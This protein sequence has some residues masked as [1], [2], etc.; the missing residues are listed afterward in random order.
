MRVLVTGAGGFVGLHLLRELSRAGSREL[1]GTIPAD[2]SSEWSAPDIPGVEWISLDISSMDSVSSAVS[3]VQPDLVYHLAGQ[4]SVGASFE[5]PLATWDVNATGTLRLVTALVRLSPGTRRLLLA[6]SAEVYGIIAPEDQPVCESSASSP[7]SPYGASKA[8]AEA[9]AIGA[10]RPGRLE[11]VIART[12]NQIGP[13]QDE[14]FVLPSIARQLARMREGG[15]PANILKLGNVTVER[16]FLDVRDAVS[17]YLQLMRLGRSGEA[18]NVCSGV[19]RPLSVVVGRLVELS[20][21][22]ASIA[23]DPTRVRPSDIPVLVG[24]NSKLRELGWQ[25]R[26]DLDETLRSL[27]DEAREEL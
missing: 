2:A 23:I 25:P 4:A 13:G 19:A 17:A 16:D 14:R 3:Q 10:S 9:A 12:F 27:L 5:A 24:A 22:D 26:F 6:S 7:V 18:Y 20:R 8:A 21:T 1:I 15:G 11:V